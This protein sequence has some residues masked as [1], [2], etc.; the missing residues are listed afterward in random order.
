[1]KKIS[2]IIPMYNSFSRLKPC[3]KILEN[4][5]RKRI[6]VIVVDD[7]STDGSYEKAIEYAEHG[8]LDIKI[9]KNSKNVG[10]G[11]SR[12]H[13]IEFAT[14]DYITFVDSDDC[15]CADFYDR[16]NAFMEKDIDCVIFDY[17]NVSETGEKISS[18]KSIGNNTIKEGNLDPQVALVY[19]YGSTC[20]KLYKKKI[21]DQYHICFGEFFRSE[22]MPFTKE[23]LARCKSIYYLP[24]ELYSYVQVASSLMHDSSLNDEKNCQKAFQILSTRLTKAGYNEELQAIELR[25][26]LNNSVLT[27]IGRGCST[28]EIVSYINKK[29]KRE[30]IQNKYFRGYPLHVKIV[31]LLAYVRCVF[32]L[33]LIWRIKKWK[34]ARS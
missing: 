12:N 4:I 2:I 7:C 8:L 5:P 1:M 25:E 21:I 29:Y 26:V 28:S 11:A 32:M 18:G 17:M 22:D 9:L 13:G 27:K 31:T 10:P 30:Y 6:E 14:G 20:G 24:E 33:R 3:L 34:R 16:V 19:V 15:L 23:A